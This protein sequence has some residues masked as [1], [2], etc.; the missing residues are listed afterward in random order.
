MDAW[1]L[2]ALSS[3]IRYV[4]KK[5]SS[6]EAYAQAKNLKAKFDQALKTYEIQHFAPQRGRVGYTLDH[7]SFEA[8][9]RKH[10]ATPAA[11]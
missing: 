8:F 5:T 3:G 11:Q 10:L 4:A 6:A 9:L 2:S 1:A 7:E